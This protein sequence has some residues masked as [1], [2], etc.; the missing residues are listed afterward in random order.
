M[1]LK[2]Y[3]DE[4]VLAVKNA[5]KEARTVYD[6]K[7]ATQK[8]VDAALAQLKEAIEG[9]VEVEEETKVDKTEL[10]ALIDETEKMDLKPYTDET[11]LAVKNALKEART[12]YDNK[13]ATQKD[14]D[15]AL[16]QLKKAVDGLEKLDDGNQPNELDESD[17]AVET[18]DTVMPIGWAT[19]SLLAMFA[20]AVVLS[21]K[22][23]KK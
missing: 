8:D 1:D 9:L 19:V 16:A 5:L 21:E 20:V 17:K 6:N 4:T 23:R 12:V 7:D 15:A 13:D 22:R 3:T 2:P 11:V 18:G 14:V 10:K